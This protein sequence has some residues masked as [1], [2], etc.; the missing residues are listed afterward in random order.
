[1]DFDAATEAVGTF[2]LGSSTGLGTGTAGGVD[3]E[4][5]LDA[6]DSEPDWLF[7]GVP[8]VPLAELVDV[9]DVVFAWLFVEFVFGWLVEVDVVLLL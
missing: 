9:V 7:D 8:T 6:S 3:G 1:M 5:F 2:S 4:A